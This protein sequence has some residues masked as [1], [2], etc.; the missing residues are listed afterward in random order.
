[1][2]GLTGPTGPTGPAGPQG[3]PGQVE[4]VSCKQVTV[5]ITRKH[6]KVKVKRQKCS[7]KLVSGPVKFKTARGSGRASLSRSGVVYATGYVR[8]TL[9]GVQTRL[10]AARRLAPGRYTL[11]ITIGRGRGARATRTEVTI[12]A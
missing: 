7:T 10:L 12:R 1:V 2:P 4:L 11:R 8:R 3:T 5:T 9:T 6:H